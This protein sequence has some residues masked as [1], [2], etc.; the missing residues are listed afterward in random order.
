[1]A[2]DLA[3]RDEA[4]ARR[5]LRIY[6]PRRR[7]YTPRRRYHSQCTS[8]TKWLTSP[9]SLNP[10]HEPEQRSARRQMTSV[11]SSLLANRDRLHQD[12]VMVQ[13]Q[14][15]V[16]QP[17]LPRSTL[18]TARVHSPP[19]Q[20]YPIAPKNRSRASR[21]GASTLQARIMGSNVRRA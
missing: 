8:S 4:D 17:T 5:N 10:L 14:S 11:T 12:T 13:N 9:T 6:I 18:N 3:C 2:C 1:M 20:N 16:I 19:P 15:R 21:M 7:S